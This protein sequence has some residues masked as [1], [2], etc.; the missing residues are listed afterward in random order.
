MKTL[1]R[2][3]KTYQMHIDDLSQPFVKSNA[4]KRARILE[5]CIEEIGRKAKA[6]GAEMPLLPEIPE[7]VTSDII[8]EETGVRVAEDSGFDPAQNEGF[9]TAH[10]MHLQACREAAGVS[11]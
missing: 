1:N 9:L 10:K 4:L 3:L 2:A 11:R 5:S 8:E 7:I 6:S